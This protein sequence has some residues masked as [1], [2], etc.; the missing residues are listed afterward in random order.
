MSL[1]IN[2]ILRL[3]DLDLVKYNHNISL[4]S[5]DSKECINNSIFVSNNNMYIADAINNNAKTVILKEKVKEVKGVNYIYSDNPIRLMGFILRQLY[6]DKMK[7]ITLIGVV[8]TNGKTTVSTLGYSFFNS[9]GYQAML[10]GSNGIYYLDKHIK[11]NNTTPC[12]SLIY[13]YLLTA[14]SLNINYVFIEVSSIGV[15]QLRTFK[16]DF[17]CLIYTNFSHEHLDYHNDMNEYFKCKLIPF[18]TLDEDSYIILNKDDEHCCQIAKYS[19]AK[20]LSYGINNG[21]YQAIDPVVSINGVEFFCNNYLYKSKMIG[22]F[23]IYNILPIIA[24]GDIFKIPFYELQKFLLNYNGVCGRSQMLE[25]GEKKIIIDYAHTP[26]AIEEIVNNMYTL[27]ENELIVV[28]GCGGNRDKE[29][30]HLIGKYLNTIDC[31]IILTSDNPRNENPLDIINDIGSNI[32]NKHIIVDRRQAIDYA[33]NLMKDFDIL[34]I[35]GKGAEDYIE[36]NDVKYPYS[37]LEVCN[38]WFKCC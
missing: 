25:F 4:I 38:D 16:L 17:K 32:S 37:D 28:V 20:C 11:T 6:K 10:I 5:E 27:C 21:Y 33:L 29:K 26:K 19:K 18:L 24:L 35:L 36:I 8:G 13:K 7:K 2:T 15:H 9:I 1:K 3:L 34:L 22:S 30:R 12:L 14:Y 31:K 23:N